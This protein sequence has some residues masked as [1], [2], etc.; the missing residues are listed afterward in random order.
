MLMMG[1]LKEYEIQYG[2]SVKDT[3]SWFGEATGH[4]EAIRKFRREVGYDHLKIQYVYEWTA[5]GNRIP[6]ELW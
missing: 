2:D 4:F 6:C 1:A 5:D 3:S